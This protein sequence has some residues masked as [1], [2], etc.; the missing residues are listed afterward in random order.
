MTAALACGILAN[1]L[2]VLI[3]AGG[4]FALYAARA[5]LLPVPLGRWPA[6]VG[7]VP[8]IVRLLGAWIAVQW[9]A[10]QLLV[11]PLV[12]AG[13][14]DLFRP[15]VV[16]T[17]LGLVIVYLL[18]PYTGP[19]RAK[20][21]GAYDYSGRHRGQPGGEPIPAPRRLLGRSCPSG[22]GGRDAGRDSGGCLGAGGRT[23]GPVPGHR[24]HGPRR[25]AA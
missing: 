7:R 6:L 25:G 15:F 22:Q 19:A 16:T 23:S 9:L 4:T 21:D 20:G 24:R 17:V 11:N 5:G 14:E 13:A 8:M 3:I 12:T 10:G 2:E 18:A 1:W